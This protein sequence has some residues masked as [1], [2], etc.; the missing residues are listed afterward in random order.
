VEPNVSE[1]MEMEIVPT[2]TVGSAI[3]CVAMVNLFLKANEGYS[4]IWSDGKYVLTD[5]TTFGSG[6]R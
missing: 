2:V 1:H 5:D 6:A 4:L 3:A